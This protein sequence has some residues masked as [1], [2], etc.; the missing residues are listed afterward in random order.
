MNKRAHAKRRLKAVPKLALK[1]WWRL[2]SRK[3][4]ERLVRAYMR[5]KL[6][7][8]ER[9]RRRALKAAFE[10]A[11]NYAI[12]NENGKF[13]G[14][15]TLYNIA[16]YLLIADRDIQAVK[17]DTLTHPDEW[18]RKLGARI[19]LLTIYEWDADKVTGRQLKDA[20]ELM[21]IP[22]ELK[23]EAIESLRALRVIQRK[24]NK[25]FSFV[26]NTV[27]G[28]RDPNALVQY[29]AIRDLKVEEVMM[30]GME[31]FTEANKFINVLTRVMLAGNSM[32]S[33]LSQ[34]SASTKNS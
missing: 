2:K 29:R 24:A 18:T 7:Y 13:K 26:R 32:P 14:L 11:K 22:E 25:Q 30:I 12:K 19:I 23:R 6:P 31:F 4:A 28:H 34:W 27:I 21:L 17:I 20:L 9:K 8:M 16:L 5:R 10:T 3:L 1:R 15:S 33:F